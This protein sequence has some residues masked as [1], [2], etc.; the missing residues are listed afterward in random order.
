MR[1][2]L[3]VALGALALAGCVHHE[4]PYRGA[5]YGYGAY[6]PGYGYGGYRYHPAHAV[7]A[8]PVS[9]PAYH[10]RDWHEGWRGRRH[11]GEGWWHGG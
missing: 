8:R 7:P 10:R 1:K 2:V 9:W 11:L 3:V 4:G 5:G 6:G